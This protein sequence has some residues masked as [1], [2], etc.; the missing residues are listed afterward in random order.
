M[1]VINLQR[2]RE[3]TGGY[4]MGTFVVGC[5]VLCCVGFAVRSI[6]MGKK[7]GKSSCGGDCGHCRGCH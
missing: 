7:S 5:I 3:L 4:Y 1:Q 6:V 2:N